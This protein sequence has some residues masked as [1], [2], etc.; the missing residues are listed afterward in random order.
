ML[1]S[2]TLSRVP[3]SDNTLG[4]VLRINSHNHTPWTING[5]YR[6]ESRDHVFVQSHH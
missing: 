1:D 4:C 5:F 3:R 2:I 6:V